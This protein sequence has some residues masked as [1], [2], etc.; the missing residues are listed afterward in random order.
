MPTQSNNAIAALE[1]LQYARKYI[2]EGSTQLI[3][4]SY[5]PSKR[6]EL[7]NAVRKLREL[8]DCHPD[9]L[10]ALDLEIRDFYYGIAMSKELALGNCHELALMAL[11]YLSHQTEDVEGETYKI[12][13]GNH[14]IL[15]IGR[16]ADS[17]ATDP[18]SWGEDAYICDPWANKVFPASL[19]LTE[20]KNYYSEFD[21]ESS[22]YLNYTED[23]D[24]QKHVLQPCSATEN[25]I[26]IRTHRTKSEAHLKKVTD[27]FEKK[28][29]QMA[30]AINLL[31]EKLQKLANRL[32]QKRG[33]EDE[34][35]VAIRIILSV[36]AEAQQINTVLE[37]REYLENYL[38]LKLESAL[39]SS[40]RAFAKALATA[41]RQQ[42]T[43]GKHRVAHSKDSLV[44]HALRFF[45]RYPK[46]EKLTYEALREAE[47]TVQQIK[48]IGLQ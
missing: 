36:I 44:N 47:Q 45:H 13:G 23:F 32:A 18:L 35:T 43:L 24:V 4:N 46:S 30:Q 37:N 34:K 42:Q 31:H 33:E 6:N 28:S 5:P 25:S 39:N 38:P 12:E 7:R 48:S 21:S 17:V 2:L 15:V 29:V 1:A 40:Q 19:Y 8:C 9:Y 14:V 26:Y 41:S 10:S 3:N 20:L 22:S 16:K 27:M 11:D